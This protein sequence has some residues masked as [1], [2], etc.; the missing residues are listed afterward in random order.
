MRAHTRTI[1]AFCL[2]ASAIPAAAQDAKPL[3][4]AEALRALTAEVAKELTVV[5]G[6]S[7]EPL[8]PVERISREK[9]FEEYVLKSLNF[10]W[11]GD[12]ERGLTVFKA[13]GMIPADLEAKPFLR[14]YSAVLTAAAY[15]F[16]GRRIV[17]PETAVERDVLLH[18]LVHALTDER[19]SIRKLMEGTQF[20]FDRILAMGA[21]IEGEATNVQLRYRIGRSRVLMAFVPY[22]TLS[23]AAHRYFADLRARIVLWLPDVPPNIVH[24]QAFVYDEGVLF[25]ERLRRCAT[26]WSAVDAAYAMPPRST[27]QVLH[28]RQYIEGVWPI[29]L[30]VVG[31]DALLPGYRLEATD[32][33][34]EYG[35][36]LF[37]ATHL[38]GLQQ[39][40]RAAW[41][42]RGDRLCF[43]RRRV[44]ARPAL[45]WVTTWDS[46]DKAREIET[47]LAAALE[48]CTRNV[49]WY[50]PQ[51]PGP[52]KAAVQVVRRDRDVVAVVGDVPARALLSAA[53]VTRKT[54]EEKPLAHLATP[55]NPDEAAAEKE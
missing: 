12:Y 41:G 30:T 17:F 19:H 35:M 29:E 52:A 20:E 42:W 6:A 28:P 5:R 27:S 4:E 11:G 36:R 50:D 13:L 22:G 9:Y 3:S 49:S 45:L 7:L 53:V 32:V 23:D 37:L 48:A 46:R 31:A 39:P 38:P 44:D 51:A 1:C 14:K 16:L 10:T 26:G 25:V 54:S 34:G 15:D 2:F 47:H 21:L 55:E 8:P 43:Y 24:T 18:E 40:E 33:L